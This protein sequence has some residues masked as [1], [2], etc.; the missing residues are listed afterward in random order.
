MYRLASSIEG[1]DEELPII[2]I[3]H[4]LT[5]STEDIMTTMQKF[6]YLAMK[7]DGIVRGWLGHILYFLVVDPLDLEFVLR[8]CLEK[9]DLHRFIRNIL[10]YGGIYA[11]VAIWRKRRKIL[12]PAFSPKIVENFVEVFSEQSEKLAVKLKAVEGCGQVRAW[13]FL[14][15]YTLDAVCETAMGIKINAQDNPNAPFLKAMQIMLNLVTERISHLWLQPDWLYKFFPQYSKHQKYLKVMH[16]FIDEVIHNKR[17]DLKKE[18]SNQ[19]EMDNDFNLGNYKR[20]SFLDHLINLSGCKKGY[21]DKELREEVLTL[22]I[23]GIDTSALTIGF[24]LKLLAKYPKVQDRVFQELQEV[25]GNSNR[26]LVKEDLINLKYLERVVKE[27]LR[28]FPPGPFIIRKVLQDLA[29]PSGRILPA[30]SGIVVSI[31]GVHRDPKYWGPNAE[32]FDPDRFL[33]ERFNLQHA[34]SYMPFSNGPRNCVAYQY[35][36]MSVKTAL[37]AILRRYKIVGDEEPGPIPF[38]KTKLDIMMKAVDDY[39]IALEKRTLI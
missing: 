24:T 27:T 1:P 19:P 30:G 21:S 29:L 28:L 31:W 13:P 23:A 10:G 15:T 4:T 22:T 7:N 8:T 3:A 35:A 32:C 12:I 25:F 11:P 16:D 26:P 20:Q 33:P 17:E 2:G 39:E 6:S 38:I 5:G 34:C 9:D 36:L 14:S 37:S 18:R